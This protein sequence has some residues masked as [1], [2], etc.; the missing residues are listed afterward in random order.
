MIATQNA[1]R[2]STPDPDFQWDADAQ[3]MDILVANL[4]YHR[5]FKIQ[6]KALAMLEHYHCKDD[7]LCGQLADLL[8]ANIKATLPRQTPEWRAEL[9]QHVR[10][11]WR[12]L[13][14][15]R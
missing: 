8:D 7:G 6:Q 10:D 12:H 4:F 5:E 9:H 15:L 11:F 1:D 3:N 13:L 14:D 2:C